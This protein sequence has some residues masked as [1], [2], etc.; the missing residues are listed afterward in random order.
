MVY[1]SNITE[2][3][4]STTLDIGFDV[5]IV[6]ATSGNITV[7]LP[8][9]TADGLQYKI[10]RIDNNSNRV[11]ITGSQT[12]DGLVSIQLFPQNSIEIH[13]IDTVWRTIDNITPSVDL[14]AG[15]YY[16]FFVPPGG[17]NGVNFRGY[18]TSNTLNPT[19]ESILVGSISAF[20]ISGSPPATFDPTIMT[21]SIEAVAVRFN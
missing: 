15:M 14:K 1:N 17:T 2:I 12:I 11:T 9:I 21:P 13:S 6:D 10:K 20:T 18:V 16:I 19:G 5:Y 4:T 3:T 7:T 8:S